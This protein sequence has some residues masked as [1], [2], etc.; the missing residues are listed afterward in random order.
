MK[1]LNYD[2]WDS[3]IRSVLACPEQVKKALSIANYNMTRPSTKSG[4][5]LLAC[6]TSYRKLWYGK[7][8][9]DRCSYNW[10]K[11]MSA[12][13]ARGELTNTQVQESTLNKET[14]M[15]IPQPMPTTSTQ[16][17]PMNKV[18]YIYG[19]ALDGMSAQDIMSAI[20]RAK[21]DITTLEDVGEESKY[22]AKQVRALK[23]VITLLVSTLDKK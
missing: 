13:A 6:Q 5:H 20:T 1:P 21:A 2:S 7:E 15:N 12:I 16:A 19:V 22:I 8:H 11:L 14:T 18:T 17:V 10:S 3:L 9:A 4:W 23:R